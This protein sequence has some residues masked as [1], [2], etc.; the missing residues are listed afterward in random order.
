MAATGVSPT[1]NFRR[2]G[3]IPT[4]CFAHAGEDAVFVAR[5]GFRRHAAKSGAAPGDQY[6]VVSGHSVLPMVIFAL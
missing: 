2:A 5:E 1:I 3:R 6:H 4:F